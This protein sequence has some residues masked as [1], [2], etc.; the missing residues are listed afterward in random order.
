[1]GIKEYIYSIK[2]V[3]PVDDFKKGFEEIEQYLDITAESINISLNKKRLK[4]PKKRPKIKVDNSW[5]LKT[6]SR[7]IKFNLRKISRHI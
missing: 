6:V 5:R 4:K 2:N 3:L 7:E 1:M